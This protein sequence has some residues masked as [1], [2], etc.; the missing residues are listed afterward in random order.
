MLHVVFNVV[1]SGMMIANRQCHY[2]KTNANVTSAGE[3]GRCC[4]KLPPTTN[5]NNCFGAVR[6]LL[7]A[8]SIETSERT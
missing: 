5:V 8:S 1:I 7:I 4:S 2:G 6:N 3:P